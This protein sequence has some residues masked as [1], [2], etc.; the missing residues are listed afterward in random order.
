MLPLRKRCPLKISIGSHME[1]DQIDPIDPVDPL[2]PVDV[3]KDVVVVRKRPTWVHQTL[4]EVEGNVAPRGTFRVRK[5]PQRY[6]CYVAT[7]NHIN[8]FEP[9]CYE[10]TTSHL[11]WRD[12]MME[13]YQYI[14][15]NDVWN[16]VL[17]P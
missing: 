3:P 2:A 9:S 5:I 7:M 15:K 6:S 10:E 4:Q 8:H 16:I 11:V 17:R 12:V 13:E 1:I 14:M